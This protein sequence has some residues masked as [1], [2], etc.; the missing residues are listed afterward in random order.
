MRGEIVTRFEHVDRD[1]RKKLGDLLAPDR[2]HAGRAND[3][4]R[5]AGDRPQGEQRE[6]LERFAQSHFVGQQTV[7]TD[8][9]KVV[10]PL[11]AAT[12][13]RTQQPG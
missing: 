11:H 13:V 10:Q 8:L 6:H 9:A 3:Q 4:A 1:L 2:H 12:L 5:P 7:T